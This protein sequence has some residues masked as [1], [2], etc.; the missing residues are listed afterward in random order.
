M[1]NSKYFILISIIFLILIL[2]LAYIRLSE[3]KVFTY[4]SNELASRE[5]VFNFK[6]NTVS[7]SDIDFYLS[8]CNYTAYCIALNGKAL[9]VVDDKKL[10][11]GQSW[12]FDNTDFY[13]QDILNGFYLI[14]CK[15]EKDNYFFLFKKR[16]GIVA[17]QPSKGVWHFIRG[18]YGMLAY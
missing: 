3:T 14:N 2:F 10:T 6:K 15:N 17:Y 7:S 13:V 18:K 11:K 12:R 5:V 16:K 1:K 8:N 4:K 9:F